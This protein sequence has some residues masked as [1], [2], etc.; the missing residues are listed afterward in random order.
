MQLSFHF[1]FCYFVILFL[2][3]LAHWS[4]SFLCTTVLIIIWFLC[5][6]VDVVWHTR[7]NGQKRRNRKIISR[8]KNTK[9]RIQKWKETQHKKEEEH[10]NTLGGFVWF[11]PKFQVLK[12]INREWTC[13]H[14]FFH[15]QAIAI[16]RWPDGITCFRK[17]PIDEKIEVKWQRR[18]TTVNKPH[19]GYSIETCKSQWYC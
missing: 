6:Y 7:T 19:S 1:I 17:R 15:T 12:D 2:F 11:K 5:V 13:R 18:Q 4:G 14:K 8:S 16:E 3:V 10:K 9:R